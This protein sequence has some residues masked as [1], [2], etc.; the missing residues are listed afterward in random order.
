MGRSTVVFAIWFLT[1]VSGLAQSGGDETAITPDVTAPSAAPPPNLTISEKW[2]RFLDETAAPLT[3]AAG[4]FN[5][6]LSQATN[7]DPR[8]GMGGIPF[9]E[10][11]G[12]STTDIVSQN[13]FGDFVMAAVFREDVRYRRQGP[14]YGGFWKRSGYAVSRAFITQADTG[15][16]T[17][18]WSNLT[19][20]AMSAG[21]SNLYYPPASR[22]GGA[23]AMHFGTS[24]VGGG[25]AN[26]FPEFWP[27][28][29]H[30]LV[31]H[32]LFPKTR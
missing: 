6:V 16:S 18:N 8:Y 2:R 19:G 20:T 24:L 1:G 5:G 22:T 29:H 15:G 27:G 7:S 10:R 21:F 25:L 26:L 30:V 12:A 17:F 32:H 23:M 28:I 3:L 14:A 31:R 13:F 11:L 4:A 9:A